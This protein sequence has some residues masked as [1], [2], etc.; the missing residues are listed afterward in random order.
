[1]AFRMTSRRIPTSGTISRRSNFEED[2][3]EEI[4]FD[5]QDEDLGRE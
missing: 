1:M 5:G 3:N 2:L 4:N